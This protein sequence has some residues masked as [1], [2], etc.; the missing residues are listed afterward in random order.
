MAAMV[1]DSSPLAGGSTRAR[2]LFQTLLASAERQILITTPY[3]LPDYSARGEMIKAAKER[4]VEVKVI[5]PGQRHDHLLTRRSSRRL[6]G[7]LLRGG[8]QLF[9]YRPSMIHAKI[10]IVDGLWC[11]VGS[12]NFDNRSFGLNDE[13]NLAAFGEE[14]AARLLEDYNRDLAHCQAISYAK[15]V[16]RPVWE[17][18]HE[19]IGWFLERQQ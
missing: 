4:G 3:F 6:Y 12:T 13:V 18:I 17:R 15:W 9:E 11:V 10:M 19:W 2:M 7:E 16:R 8:I 5:A 14:L 1:V